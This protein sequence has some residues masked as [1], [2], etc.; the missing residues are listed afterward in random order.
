MPVG[1][2]PQ[3]SVF[4]ETIWGQEENIVYVAY[5]KRGTDKKIVS[6]E[7]QFYGW[8]SNR[9]R[10]LADIE[11]RKPHEEVYF[12]PSLFI[13][14]D[15]HKENVKGAWVVWVD[16]DG[17]APTD[18]KGAPEP[19]IKVSSSG[20]GHEHWYWRLANF[21]DVATIES[22]NRA[23][24]HLFSADKSGWDAN[25]VLRPPNTFNH[26][27]SRSV[28]LVQFSPQ[29]LPVGLFQ[30]L[31]EPPPLHVIDIVD[32]DLP[33][34]NSVVFKYQFPEAVTGL[35]TSVVEGPH[36]GQDGHRSSSLMSL[37]YSFAEMNLTDLEMLALLANAAERWGKFEGRPDKRERLSEI[38]TIARKKYPYRAGGASDTTKLQLMGFKSLLAT[39]VKLDWIWE[40]WLQEAGF[41]L[42]AGPPGVGKTQVTLDVACHFALGKDILGRRVTKPR[43]L[44]FFSLEMGLV[45]LKEFMILLQAAFTPEE[46]EILEENFLI[47]PLGEPLYLNR[48]ETK[49][50]VEEMIGD[51]GLDGIILD[52]LSST[53]EG[54]ISTLP[55]VK[56]LLDWNDRMRQ[57]FNCFS[58]IIHHMRKA[59]S[60]NKKPN[61]LGDVYGPYLLTARPTSVFC[62]WES[63]VVNAIEVIPLKV[64]LSKRPD[65]FYIRRGTDLHF[66][67]ISSV[68]INAAPSKGA[69]A[70][71]LE[72]TDE[73]SKGDMSF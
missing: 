70:R 22:I 50:Q 15:A 13:K 48:A 47:L 52:S 39:E 72:V 73:P 8:P 10:L 20:D 5:G 24:V 3:T 65:H 37:G 12:C 38:I 46:Q 71:T 62:L 4:L 61:K 49:L 7:Q 69:V 19:T 51:Y 40:G 56:D 23:F 14:E 43:K 36:D 26:K 11:R 58:W 16:F 28:E 6:W 33:D 25:Q 60:D 18:L 54:D 9:E 30:G 2:N 64:R 68:A 53:T 63:S 32:D 66:E 44:A 67:L 31:P 57:R 21:A 29:S 59:T 17:N 42:L 27:R 45:D 41:M 35:F 34:V 55:P 1:V